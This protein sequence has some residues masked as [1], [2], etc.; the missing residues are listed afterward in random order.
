MNKKKIVENFFKNEKDTFEGHLFEKNYGGIKD[1][2]IKEN[3]ALDIFFNYINQF[4]TEKQQR[5]ANRLFIN[6]EV[7]SGGP[8]SYWEYIYYMKGLKEAEDYYKKKIEKIEEK[9]KNN[10]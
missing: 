9:N 7:A 2:E 4:L 3:E 6:F 8:I 10:N 5:K 1:Y